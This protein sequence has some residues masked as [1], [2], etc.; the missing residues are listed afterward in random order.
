MRRVPVASGCAE[1]RAGWQEQPLAAFDFADLRAKRRL[2]LPGWCAGPWK[3][4]GK[5]TQGRIARR[6]TPFRLAEA[7]Q[8]DRRGP[9]PA[10]TPRSRHGK[11]K[12]MHQ[13]TRERQLAAFRHEAR[14]RELVAVVGRQERARAS[15]R[16]RRVDRCDTQRA[17]ANRG[18]CTRRSA[19]ERR[20]DGNFAI[21]RAG[22]KRGG[23]QGAPAAARAAPGEGVRA[24]LRAGANW[25]R[26]DMRSKL[27]EERA[28]EAARLVAEGLTLDAVAERLGVHR[29]TLLRWVERD[30]VLP[31]PLRAGPP[32]R[33]RRGSTASC[34]RR[35][36]ARAG[37]VPRPTPPGGGSCA[38]RPRST[39]GCRR[40]S[41][42][43]CSTARARGG[44]TGRDRLPTR[45]RRRTAAARSASS[46]RRGEVLAAA[47]RGG[48]SCQTGVQGAAWPPRP[49]QGRPPCRPTGEGSAGT[50][51]PADPRLI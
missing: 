43:P 13:R 39:A 25:G 11:P 21:V 3:R 8:P 28:E 15:R 14:G 20:Q 4:L 22:A 18:R 29:R 45:A 2:P 1:R 24:E 34:S 33:A 6:R 7:P 12:G 37:R 30:P 38:A 44:R 49:Q 35:S 27:T 51:A 32:R 23:G 48:L 50:G 47:A 36:S 9:A 17:G 10:P 19:G 26:S 41:G 31:R 40:S 46:E 42:R 5:P 16:E